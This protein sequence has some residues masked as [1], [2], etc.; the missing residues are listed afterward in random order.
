MGRN[1]IIFQHVT[2]GSNNLIQSPSLGAPIIGDNCY[3]GA[4]A[5]II[6]KITL[7]NNVR[8][9]A[10]AIVV[11]D[12]PDNS[13]VTLG[14]QHVVTRDHPLNNSFCQKYKGRWRYFDNGTWYQ[15]DD[16]HE[17]ELLESRFPTRL[18]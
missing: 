9:G 12:V 7:G 15:V 10:N 16:S 18:H 8:V 3:I 6:G 11:R 14:E 1:C 2:I 5:K 17:L 4:G 13:I